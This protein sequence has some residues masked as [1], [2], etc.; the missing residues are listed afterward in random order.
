MRRTI[1]IWWVIAAVAVILVCFFAYSSKLS[2]EIVLLQSMLENEQIQLA[3]QEA[4]QAELEAKLDKAGT[5]AYIENEARN[6]YD[7]MMP[8]EMR[9]IISNPYGSSGTQN[10]EMP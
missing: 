1:N 8:N 4:N 6:E 7:Y 5:D 9:F 3:Q 10:A 2:D